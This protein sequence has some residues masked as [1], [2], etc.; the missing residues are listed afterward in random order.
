MSAPQTRLGALMQYFRFSPFGHRE[1]KIKLAA[2]HTQ[3]HTQK[4]TTAY[5]SIIAIK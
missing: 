5:T 2:K 1:D 3:A 4:Q